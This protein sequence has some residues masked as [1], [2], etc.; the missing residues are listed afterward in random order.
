M[1]GVALNV[2]AVAMP[3]VCVVLGPAGLPD[4]LAHPRQSS[5]AAWGLA[6]PLLR[7]VGPRLA[8]RTSALSLMGVL[9]VSA[10][11][12]ALRGGL[13]VGCLAVSVLLVLLA[14]L[15]FGRRG[16]V[17]ALLAVVVLD[18]DE[19]GSRRPGLRAVDSRA[20]SATP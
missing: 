19:R 18:R 7:L 11:M 9:M 10:A 16:A 5:C 6:F 13:T 12:V 1:L 8:F 15:F 3:L 2:L 14:T 4:R 20:S 17:L